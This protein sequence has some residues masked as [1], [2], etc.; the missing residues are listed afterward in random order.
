[1][2]YSSL[3]FWLQ[4]AFG[5]INFLLASIALFLWWPKKK[6]HTRWLWI[7]ALYFLLFWL[8]MHT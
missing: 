5:V 2:K 6:S 4:V 1:M 7:A 8:Y 3:P